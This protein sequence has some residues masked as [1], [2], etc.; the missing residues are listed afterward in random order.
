VQG[1]VADL[2]LLPENESVINVWVLHEVYKC[3]SCDFVYHIFPNIQSL[4]IKTGCCT[5]NRIT[6]TTLHTLIN[7]SSCI[8]LNI[9][10]IE[11]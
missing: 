9:H 4:R 1:I 3:V 5:A 10:H 2:I 11:T 8:S 7:Y 6:D